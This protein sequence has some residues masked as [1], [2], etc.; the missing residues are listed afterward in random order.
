MRSFIRVTFTLFLLFVSCASQAGKVGDFFKDLYPSDHRRLTGEPEKGHTKVSK[1]GRLPESAVINADPG[2]FAQKASEVF[3]DFQTWRVQN[4]ESLDYATA[5]TAVYTLGEVKGATGK[6][7]ATEVSVYLTVH[8]LEW[9]IKHLPNVF[10]TQEADGH[11]KKCGTIFMAVNGV[12]PNGKFAEYIAYDD[13]VCLDFDSVPVTLENFGKP[14]QPIVAEFLEPRVGLTQANMYHWVYCDPAVLEVFN[15][16]QESKKLLRLET[17]RS[18]QGT[19]IEEEKTYT[20]DQKAYNGPE[21]L[22]Q[23]IAHGSVNGCSR[24]RIYSLGRRLISKND[25][26]T[27]VQVMDSLI[28]VDCNGIAVPI[29]NGVPEPN[30]PPYWR[31]APRDWFFFD[32]YRKH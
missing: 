13:V 28:D 1:I 16:L 24:T 32:K 20:C 12:L 19:P 25:E 22:H 29:I 9:D 2:L 10:T 14:D 11:R 15:A 17:R 26:G 4:P 27:S 7:L 3:G 6:V 31:E 8:S 18:K 5:P 30:W 23:A 21:L